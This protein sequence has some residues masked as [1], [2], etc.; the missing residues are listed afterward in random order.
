[1]TGRVSSTIWKSNMPTAMKSA[2]PPSANLNAFS[3]LI[4]TAAR[5]PEWS[6]GIHCDRAKPHITSLELQEDSDVFAML[7]ALNAGKI[8]S[9]ELLYKDVRKI[10]REKY[11]EK[12]ILDQIDWDVCG[13]PYFYENHHLSNIL[14]NDTKQEGGEEYWIYYN[15]TKFSGKKVLVRPG[16]SF[17]ASDSG[18]YNIFVWRGKGRFDGNVIEAQNPSC[19]ELLVTHD[20]AVKPLTIINEGKTDLMLFKFFGPDINT[21]IPMIGKK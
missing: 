15:T 13:D 7:Q 17:T 20:R 21:D 9:K 18:I 1:M 2:P 5:G 4:R 14:I 11:G 3:G 19:D 8:I 10:D 6:G 16:A 12:I